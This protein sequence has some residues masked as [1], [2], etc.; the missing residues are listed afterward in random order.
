MTENVAAIVGSGLVG[1]AWATQISRS[2]SVGTH[3]S[4]SEKDRSANNCHSDT[5][6]CRC[7][8]AAPDS[9]EC[10]ASTSDSV[11]MVWHPRE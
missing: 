9:T 4:R 11:D 7:A 8:T 10:S 6:V 5:T 3:N 2:P 1:R